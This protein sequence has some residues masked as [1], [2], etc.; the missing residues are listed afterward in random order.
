VITEY[1]AQQVETAL[2]TLRESEMRCASVRKLIERRTQELRL[3]ADRQEQKQTDEFGSR[4]A[5]GN[6]ASP[7]G[8]GAPR[9]A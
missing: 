5:W 9:A 8:L 1:A 7:F 3:S 4:M 6:A 2:A